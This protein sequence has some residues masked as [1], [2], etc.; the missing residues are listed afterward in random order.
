MWAVG[1]MSGTSLDGIDA[2]LIRS[3]GLTV[4]TF[5]PARTYPYPAS[6]SAD[7]RGILGETAETAEVARLEQDLTDRH[8]EAV[9]SL[10][11]D[12]GLTPAEIAV[13]GF[14]GQTIAHRPDRRYTRQ[15]GDGTRLAARLGCPVV[16]DFRSRDVQAGGEGAPLVPV[17]H[18]ALRDSLV[19]SQGETLAVLNIGGVA[20]VTCLPAGSDT[21]LAFDTGPGNALMDDWALRHTGEAVDRDGAL[22]RR[23]QVDPLALS[24]L[25]SHPYFDRSPPKSLDRD[26]FAAL[27]RCVVGLSAPDGAATLAAFTVEAC[28]RACDWMP[29]RPDRWL[30]CGG[31]RHNPVLMA[32]LRTRLDVPVDPVEAVGWDG[33]ALEAQA[34][35]FLALRHLQD[36]PQ[37]FPGTTGCPAPMTGGRLAIG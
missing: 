11:A 2:A 18:R 10:L 8:A 21:V 9:L 28:A 23:G 33:D 29:S 36:L 24:Q 26:D 6:F 7:M 22:A 16:F 13:V 5:G 12:A 25:L 34:F 3:D 32:A 17:Y 19:A 1:L 20:N 27:A 31:G 14:H 4:E 37:T 15:I 30:I 35:A